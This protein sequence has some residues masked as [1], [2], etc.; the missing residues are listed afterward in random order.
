MHSN[1]SLNSFFLYP[2]DQLEET[3]RFVRARLGKS[4]KHV[5]ELR[6]VNFDVLFTKLLDCLILCESYLADGWMRKDDGGYV[7]VV[8]L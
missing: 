4:V 1:H 5:S 3:L 8:H 7:F 2:A 6:A